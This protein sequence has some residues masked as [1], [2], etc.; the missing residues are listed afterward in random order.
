ME[1]R[2]PSPLGEDILT[3]HLQGVKQAEREGFEAGVKRG[4][5]ALF[6]IAV[7]LV[8]SQTLI[9]YARQ[10]LTLQF[11]GLVLFFGTFFAAMGFYTHKRPFVAL[12]AGT[13]GYIS[14]WVIDLACG[15]ARGGANMATGVLVRVAFTIFLIRALPAARRLEQL[16]RNG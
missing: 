5:N 2:L 13:L 7:L 1:N 16:K 12:L 6:W 4:R 11:L 3:N 15:Y 14:L 8:L 10:E 9:S